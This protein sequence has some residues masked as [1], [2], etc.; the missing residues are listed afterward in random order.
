MPEKPVLLITGSSRGIG[1]YLAQHYVA[2]GMEVV[3]CSRGGEDTLQAP[4]YTH[5]AIDVTSEADVVRLFR[6]IRTRFGRLDV[7]I[8]NA[9]VNPTMS[10]TL[11]TSHEAAARTLTTNVLGT[12]VVAREACKIMMRHK[13]GRIVNFS[14][15]AARHEVAGEAIYSASK[16]AIH[17]LTRVMAKEFYSYGVTCNVVAPSAMETGMTAAVESDAL[18]EVLARNAIPEMGK[19]SDVANTIDW[20]IKP[21][22][23]AVTG[24]VIFLGGA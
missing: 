22:S 9:G 12:F 14:S 17:S 3:G 21:E 6:E 1:R 24:Q 13:W 7:A 2:Q 20:L 4:N 5:L 15:M 23:Q 10:L 18:R 16:A 11:L 19:M 8:N